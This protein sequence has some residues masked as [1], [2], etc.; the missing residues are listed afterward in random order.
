M[1]PLLCCQLILHSDFYSKLSATIMFFCKLADR[2]FVGLPV[3]WLC[4]FTDGKLRNV[5]RF[6]APNF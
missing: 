1:A 5:Y 4:N 3:K 6:W 2:I